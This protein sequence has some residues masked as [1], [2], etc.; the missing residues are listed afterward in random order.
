MK[1][2]LNRVILPAVACMMAVANVHGA[3]IYKTDFVQTPV[4]ATTTFNKGEFIAPPSWGVGSMCYHTTSSAGEVTITFT[5][6]IDLTA[7]SNVKLT[8]YWGAS[9]NRP[10]N[11]TINGGT[12]KEIDKVGSSSDRSKTRSIDVSITE[13]SIKSLKFN[14][15]GGGNSYYFQLEIT[16]DG[17]GTVIPVAGVS[18]NKDKLTLEEGKSEKLTATVDP[19]GATNT[20][21]TW[22]SSN[23]SVATVDEQGN[24]TAVSVGQT[25]VTVKTDDGGFTATCAVTVTA[26]TTPVVH[27]DG[28]A[29]AKSHTELTLYVNDTQQ[30]QY[31]ITPSDATNKAVTWSVDDPSVVSVSNG[32]VTALKKGD[33]TVTV[34]TVDGQKT[35]ESIIH[36]KEKEV[37]VPS[38]DLKVHETEVYESPKGYD[39]EL[40]QFNGRDYEVYYPSFDS[41]SNLSV[42]TTPAQKTAGITESI[43]Q[44]NAKAIDGWLEINLTDGKSNKTYTAKDEFAAGEG[45]LHKLKSDGYYKMHIKGF[46]QFSFYG[47]DNNSD[48]SK[49]RMFEVLIDGVKQATTPITSESVRRFNIS[50]DEHVIELIGRGSS[51]NE[52]YGFSLRVAYVPKVKHISGNDSTQNVLQTQAMQ[53]VTYYLKNKVSDAEFSWDGAEATGISM[54]KSANDTLTVSGTA[55]CKNG[56]YK[57]TISAKDKDGKV[58]STKTGTITVS[59]KVAY[60]RMIDSVKTVYE[61]ASI[62]PVLFNYYSIDKSDLS[63]RWTSQTPAGLSFTADESAHTLTLSGTPTTV[64]TFPYEVTLKDANTLKG[65]ITVLSNSPTVVPGASKT[66]LYLYKTERTNNIYSDLTRKYNYFARPAGGAGKA[67]SDYSDYD[68]IVIS[69]DADAN[70]D[71]V[72]NIIKNVKKPVLNMKNFTYTT[73]R[74][75]WGYPDNGSVNNTEITVLQPQHPVFK[76]MNVEEGS[77]I[78]LLSQVTG[79][80]LMPSEITLQGSYAL[81]T[82]LKQGAQYEA[83]GEPET[84]LHEVPQATRGAKYILFPLSEQSAGNLTSDGRKLLQNVIEYLLSTEESKVV[85]HELKITSFSI[86]GH[87]AQIDE[88]QQEIHL[89]LPEGTDLTQLTP[90][91]TLANQKTKVTPSSGTTLNMSDSYFGVDFTVSDFINRKVYTAYITTATSLDDLSAEGLWYDGKVLHNPQGIWVN[92]YNVQ[93]MLITTTNADYSF[94]SQPQSMYMIVSERGVMKVMN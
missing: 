6:P 26:S 59:S 52:L 80:G 9:S 37:P 20:K 28:I 90:Q 92:I 64:G 94:E 38:T 35:A 19:R 1:T 88:A 65:K 83:E 36:V 15:S 46:D 55:N 62:E 29:F 43:S 77:K 70:N 75:G 41:E 5:N 44:Y 56:V 14:G 53:P 18:L 63:W 7:Y 78:K 76:G 16:G 74:L 93:G 72:I 48:A 32:L 23:P 47:K 30:L 51:N 85:L 42:S 61:K 87:Q 11:L 68:F 71:E 45:A 49:N 91:I 54:Q 21:V 25:T 8:L 33:A 69:E 4:N 17:G 86:D 24:V 73:S 12:S 39:T 2:L 13:S 22:T 84:F 79:R 3:S 57:Y 67:D 34:T 89:E 31:S 66:M 40:T 10:V 58:I 82:A 60:Q 81:A 50:P 27:V